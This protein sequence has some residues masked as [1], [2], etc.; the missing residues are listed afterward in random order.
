MK[1]IPSQL[2]TLVSDEIRVYWEGGFILCLQR[3][4]CDLQGAGLSRVHALLC[5]DLGSAAEVF[6]C[7]WWAR[8][9]LS[10]GFNFSLQVP[11]SKFPI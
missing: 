11:Q 2:P 5:A 1:V 6:P 10:W 8:S 3:S 9:D 7:W 4:L